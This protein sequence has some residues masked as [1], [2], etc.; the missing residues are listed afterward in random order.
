MQRTFIVLTL[1]LVFAGCDSGTSSNDNQTLRIS[2]TAADA[3][4]NGFHYEGWAIIGGSPVSTGKFNVDASGD[5]VDMSGSP[6]ANGD[7]DVGRD[8]STASAIVITIEPAGDA[9]AVPAD[10]K[11]FGGDVTGLNA[12][13]SAAHGSS[14]GDSFTTAN[15][16]YI[17]A[18]PTDGSGNNE[19]SGL[20]FLDNSSGSPQ[21]ALTLPTLPAGWKYEGWA[22]INGSPVTTG[23]FTAVD[24]ADDAAPFSGAGAGPPFPGED[25]LTNAPA[26]QTFPTDLS[27]GTAV[28]SIEPF[29][30]DS[31]AP[32]TFKPLTG[33]IPAGAASGTV[34]PLM[35]NASAFPSGLAAI[36]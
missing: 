19:L 25:F 14:L 30:D 24:A 5:I 8:L 15:G 33:A 23:T 1:A 6:I 7:F 9:D 29:P 36:R 26:G 32:F 35:N 31:A 27:G 10:T 28:I 11:I 16:S 21:A 13:L 20:W 4:T 22:V 18:T 3:L 34:Y 2:L 12:T 17:L